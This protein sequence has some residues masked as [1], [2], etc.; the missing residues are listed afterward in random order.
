MG[1]DLASGAVPDLIKALDDKEA[2]VR[3]E[4]LSTLA[5]LGPE[6]EAAVSPLLDTMTADPDESIRDAVTR[7]LLVIDPKHR[8]ILPY[9]EAIR[10]EITREGFLKA[11]RRIGPEARSLRVRLQTAWGMDRGPNPPHP[12][13]PEA[14]DMV[15]WGGRCAR[16]SP[17]P[18][19]LLD[20]MWEK[21]TADEEEVGN[22]VWEDGSWSRGKIKAALNKVKQALED[23]GVP[24]RY[25]QK[26]GR[27]DKKE[28]GC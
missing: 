10:G 28:I 21:D 23:V 17:Q 18:F 14:P 22:H 6:A 8:L 24:W 1:I 9:L 16:L 19:A 5:W 2:A 27:I 12:D 7:A 13:G 20:Y 25:G 3:L 26:R 4:A 11:L 15:W